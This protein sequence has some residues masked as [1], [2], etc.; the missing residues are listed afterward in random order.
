MT[1]NQFRDVIRRLELSQVGA[2][3]LLMVDDRTARRWARDG[4]V[5]GPSAALLRLLDAGRVEVGELARLMR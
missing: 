4:N 3:R 1:A 2:A 5:P